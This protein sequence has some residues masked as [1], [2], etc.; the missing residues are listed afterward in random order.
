MI[1]KYGKTVAIIVAHPDD[2]TLWCGGTILSNPEWNTFIVCL[3][4]GNDK[5]R[6][7]RFFKALNCYG[8]K[9]I[10]GEIDDGPQQRPIDEEELN[11]AILHLLPPWHFDL[12]ITHSPCGEYTRHIRHEEISKAV[13]KLWHSGKLS[14]S[15][16]WTFAYEDNNKKYYP[17]P[18]GNADIFHTLSEI[19]WQK[20]YNIITKTYGF[21]RGSFEAETT[22]VSE[23]FWKYKVPEEAMDDLLQYECH[24]TTALNP[25]NREYGAKQKP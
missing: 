3:C 19:I 22:P 11:R 15:E 5:E 20:K 1:R 6:A 23:S 17:R 13:I 7:H 18:V 16:L 9:G 8:S 12:L 2:E 24:L 10:M 14:A 25:G 4:R 21:D